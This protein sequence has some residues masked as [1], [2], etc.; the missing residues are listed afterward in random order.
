MS[1][2]SMSATRRPRHG[3]QER[4]RANDAAADDQQVPVLVRE[5][6]QVGGAAG[7]GPVI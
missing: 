5:L 2:C 3:V 1:S 6:R 4:A 7:R